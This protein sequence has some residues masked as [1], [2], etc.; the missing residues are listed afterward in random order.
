MFCCWWCYC[1]SLYTYHLHPRCFSYSN[2]YRQYAFISSTNERTLLLKHTPQQYSRFCAASA[3]LLFHFSLPLRECAI[4]AAKPRLYTSH[5]PISNKQFYK[6][7]KYTGEQH[8]NAYHG[9][10]RCTR[11]FFYCFIQ[12][13]TRQRRIRP[14]VNVTGRRYE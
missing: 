13:G 12:S 3:Y 4:A 1:S 9:G 11:Y 8:A 7:S 10:V 5:P 2:T 6:K 14:P